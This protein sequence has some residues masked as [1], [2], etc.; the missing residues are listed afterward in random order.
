MLKG[1]FK[2]QRS[3]N[4]GLN[5]CLLIVNRLGVRSLVYSIRAEFADRI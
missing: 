2:N 4:Q 1:K 5:K 3:L